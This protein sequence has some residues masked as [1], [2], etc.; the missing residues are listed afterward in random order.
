[1]TSPSATEAFI[2]DANGNPVSYNGHLVASKTIAYTGAAN[3][4]AQGATTLF[5][6]TGDVAASIFAVCTEDLA[7]ATATIEVGISGNTAAL[8]AQ[9]TATNIDNGEVWATTSPANPLAVPADKVIAAGADIIQTV[10]TADITDGTLTYYC[11]WVPLT[12][13]ASVVAA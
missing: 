12:V 5:T 10:G 1:M 7:G 13:G 3:L 4:G 8:I 9:T 6:V 2:L 11:L